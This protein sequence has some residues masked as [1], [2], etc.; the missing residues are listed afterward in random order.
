MAADAWSSKSVSSKSLSC[1]SLSHSSMIESTCT[2][3]CSVSAVCP[4]SPALAACPV[5]D[6][7][8]VSAVLVP[9]PPPS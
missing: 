7:D 9:P 2:S 5:P 3:V 4:A 1:T 6:T 8:T